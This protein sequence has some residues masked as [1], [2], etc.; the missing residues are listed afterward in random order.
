MIQNFTQERERKNV[1]RHAPINFFLWSNNNLAKRWEKMI[2]KREKKGTKLKRKSDLR[3]KKRGMSF[4]I[5]FSFGMKTKFKCAKTLV[6]THSVSIT[7]DRWC[8]NNIN[9]RKS[10][11]EKCS[12]TAHYNHHRLIIPLASWMVIFLSFFSLSSHIS[13]LETTS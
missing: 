13:C 10:K 4:L 7:K 1:P 11:Q 6:V 9:E 3:N 2:R 8:S 12:R 5:L